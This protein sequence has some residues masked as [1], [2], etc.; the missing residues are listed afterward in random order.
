MN[1]DESFSVEREGDLMFAWL[2]LS[3]CLTALV[4]LQSKVR[5]LERASRQVKAEKTQLQEVSD[6]SI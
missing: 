4:A 5:T 3:A 6:A 1:D 2:K